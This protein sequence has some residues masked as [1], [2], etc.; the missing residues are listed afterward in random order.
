ME[1]RLGVLGRRGQAR[2][3]ILWCRC[4]CG[5]WCLFSLV[6]MFFRQCFLIGY[7]KF[8]ILMIGY[9]LK[10]REKRLLSFVVF[11]SISRR[12][13][14]SRC[15][16]LSRISRKFVFTFRLCISFI[17]TWF[18]FFRLGLFCSFRSKIFIVQKSRVSFRVGGL[19][20]NRIWK[21]TFRRREGFSLWL[22]RC[23]TDI[24]EM[25]RGW[26][27]IILQRVSR[28][29]VIQRFSSSWGIRVVFLQFVFLEMIIIGC[30][31]MVLRMVFRCGLIGS[32]GVF[33]QIGFRR[34][35]SFS[36]FWFRRI[37]FVF[38]R[39]MQGL[40][41]IGLFKGFEFLFKG[42]MLLFCSRS[43]GEIYELFIGY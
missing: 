18:T 15:R 4:R 36:R 25:R 20:F 26:V 29:F 34:R 31:L 39:G 16:F 28:F 21:F 9:L 5:Y 14:L 11:M 40:F 32:W 23:V 6:R 41:V 17:M 1:E 22:I 35:Y 30:C 2:F 7:M 38:D 19:F 42:K 24:V 12:V 27:M 37:F 3:F 43:F 10:Q 8:G 13:G 33:C